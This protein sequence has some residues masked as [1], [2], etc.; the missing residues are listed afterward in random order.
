MSTHAC[1]RQLTVTHHRDLRV[2]LSVDELF[3]Y[4]P[5]LYG[6]GIGSSVHPAGARRVCFRAG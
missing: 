2:N 5:A 6:M 3:L 1:S 4:I